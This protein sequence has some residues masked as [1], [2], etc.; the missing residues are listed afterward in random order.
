VDADQVL[1]FRLNR[2]GLARREARSLA[3]AAACPASDFAR[4]AALLA[5]AA[6]HDGV[7]RAAYR[8]AADGDALVLA[9]VVRGAIHALAP[10][11]LGLYGRALISNRDD[12]LGAQLGQQVQRLAAEK[13]FLPT[14]ALEEVAEA[15]AEALSGGT[16]LT[17]DELHEGLRRRVKEDLMPWCRSCKSHH[18]APMLWRYGTISAGAVLDSERRYRAGKPGRTPAAAR[19]VESFLHFYGPATTGDFA[20][21]AGVARPHAERLW[22]R[23]E[24]DLCE[25]EVA[26]RS[27]W[28]L[29]AD[30]RELEAPAAAEG[31]RLIPPGDPYLQKPN[32]ALLAP[33]K[34]LRKRLFRPVAS[35]GAILRDGRLAGLWRAKAK[36]KKLEV[37]VE[38]LG[39][40]RRP[41][42]EA[43]AQLVA[44]VRGASDAVLVV[45]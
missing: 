36:G 32:R 27:A 37:S 13:G 45:D 15:T 35:P 14:A 29:R 38:R 41:D 44:T 19:A 4:D 42:L 7:T 25:V 26:G 11:D 5:L 33:D 30:T 28:L 24:G 31:L 21:W 12:E 16:V 3:E 9:H 40:L 2:A 1:L 10:N 34:A 17:K 20:D 39:R 18:V 23:V 22:S 43:E 8:E 6:R